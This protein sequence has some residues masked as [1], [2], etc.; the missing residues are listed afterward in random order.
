MQSHFSW[1]VVVP[2]GRKDRGQMVVHMKHRRG[3]VDGIYQ[4][5]VPDSMNVNQNIYIGVYNTNTGE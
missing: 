2:L 4:C 1:L 5:E 3:G